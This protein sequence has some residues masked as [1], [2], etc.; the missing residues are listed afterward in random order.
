MDEKQKERYKLFDKLG[1]LNEDLK[2]A[3]E[4]LS[5]YRQT[6]ERYEK[7]IEESLDNIKTLEKELNDLT[8]QNL[9]IILKGI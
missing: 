8:R 1:E 6:V 3:Y 5:E 4:S 7:R 9:D 2:L